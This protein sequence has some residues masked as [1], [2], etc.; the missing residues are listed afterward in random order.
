MPSLRI[1]LKSSRELLGT[2][3]VNVH[4]ILDRPTHTLEHRFRHNV[5]VVNSIGEVYGP[6]ARREA[7]LHVLMDWR[8]VDVN[9]L[10]V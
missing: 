2:E 4:R 6:E 10:E 1:H 7:W 8:I 3:N 5:N 9:V